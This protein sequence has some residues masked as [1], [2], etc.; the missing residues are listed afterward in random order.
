[1]ASF[2]ATKKGSATYCYLFHRSEP[3]WY[4]VIAKSYLILG[5]KRRQPQLWFISLLYSF[6]VAGMK[7]LNMIFLLNTS[8]QS[9]E[10]SLWFL[11]LPELLI[12]P[13]DSDGNLHERPHSYLYEQNRWKIHIKTDKQHPKTYPSKSIIANRADEFSW[14]TKPN[15]NTSCV[16]IELT[17]LFNVCRPKCLQ[18]R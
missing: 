17:F 5:K 10:Y 8:K 3:L 12:I 11:I 13:K 2:N 18:N 1:M 15:T 9:I 6:Y 4:L 14:A 16:H 7:I